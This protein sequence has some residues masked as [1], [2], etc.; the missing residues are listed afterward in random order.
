[1][2]KNLTVIVPSY[3]EEIYIKDSIERVLQEPYV[4][5]I[6]VVDDAS[7]DKTTLIV[8]S[9]IQNFPMI[10][11]IKLETNGGKGQAISKAKN[12]INSDYVVIHDADLEYNPKDMKE[13]Y[14]TIKKLNEG[15]VLGSRFLKKNKLKYIRTYFANKFF[16]KLFSFVYRIKVTD[17]ATCYKMMTTNF[18]NSIEITK[19]GF[20]VEIEILSKYFKNFKNYKEVPIS[21]SGRSYEE[22]KK[23][24]IYDG[25]KYVRAIFEFRFK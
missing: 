19:S 8:S 9:L 12:L 6:I 16:S 3:N 4:K 25:I 17:V 18:F 24:K 11:L 7:E 22:G 10:K 23:I 2:N 13:M 21:Y 15:F 5:E 1:M 14:E 20:D